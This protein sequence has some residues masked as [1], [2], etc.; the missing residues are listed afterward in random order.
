MTSSPAITFFSALMGFM[1]AYTDLQLGEILASE[2]IADQEKAADHPKS[3]A[4]EIPGITIR[5]TSSD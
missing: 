5:H 4:R 2:P 3:S 1:K